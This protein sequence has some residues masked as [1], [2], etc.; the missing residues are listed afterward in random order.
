MIERLYGNY[1]LVAVGT[2]K[3]TYTDTLY[4]SI[5]EVQRG[6][7]IG[8]NIAA[9]DE[10][11]LN[12]VLY[13][14]WT[15]DD[16]TFSDRIWT[17]KQQLVNEVYTQL[18]QNMILGRTPEASVKAIADKFKVSRS[19]AGRL[20]M[21]ESAAFAA[22]AQKDAFDELSV[23]RYKVVETLDETTCTICGGMDGT[24]HN[25]SDFEIGVTAPPFHPWCRGCTAPHF[26]DNVGKR[27]ARDKDGN[28]VY[29][30]SDMKY[31]D[32]KERF[33]DKPMSESTI[34][35]HEQGLTNGED[36]GIMRT[37]EDKNKEQE[38]PSSAEDAGKTV[39]N[40]EKTLYEVEKAKRGL[41]YEVGT[42]V[43]EDGVM[44]G[45]YPGET[46]GIRIP[47][48]DKHLFEGN[49]FTHNHPGGKGFTI[50][51]VMTAADTGL[52]EARVSTPQ[53]SYF[54]LRAGDEANRSIGRVMREE[55]AGDH[56]R[57]MEIINEGVA[58]GK[59]PEDILS[60]GRSILIC[61]TM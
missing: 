46:H 11:R 45:A 23:E 14:P 44:A 6:T 20:V 27:I 36:G 10:T 4:H 49:V 57:A 52:L 54:S 58:G 7:N 13:K 53:G 18:T 56:L 40:L 9:I 61:I 15:T 59:Y 5:Y 28:T 25:M 39:T 51:D 43:T 26:D 48:E 47:E 24:V 60:R 30:P 33:I 22:Q 19:Q 50:K 16:R 55:R 8:W 12:K 41:D 29:V 1:H 42:L 37:V 38:K 35:F 31:P 2:L 17:Q 32:W 21:T 34:Q 3:K